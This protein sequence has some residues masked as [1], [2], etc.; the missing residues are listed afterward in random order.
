MPLPVIF[1][2]ADIGAALNHPRLIVKTLA[3]FS[4]LF[5][6]ANTGA[7]SEYCDIEI[8][9]DEGAM[10]EIVKWLNELGENP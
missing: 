3:E 5:Q 4:R 9:F 6:P 10:E 7:M 1:T 8:T 2:R